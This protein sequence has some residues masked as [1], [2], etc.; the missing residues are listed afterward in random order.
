MGVCPKLYGYVGNR[1]DKGCLHCS[2]GAVASVR[3]FWGS[4]DR[5]AAARAVRGATNTMVSCPRASA[6][7]LRRTL[8]GGLE[9]VAP[10]FR[11]FGVR[12]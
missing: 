12:L 5:W 1:G 2:S 11:G 6:D 8:F 4:C 3:H 10:G 7:F 9:Q